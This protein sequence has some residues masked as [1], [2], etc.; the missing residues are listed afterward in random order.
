M[1]HLLVLDTP[2]VMN[3]ISGDGLGTRADEVDF[4]N[5]SYAKGLGQ[6]DGQHLTFS[7]DPSNKQWP[8]D[9]SL[10]VGRPYT[11]DVRVLE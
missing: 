10:P 7:I 4:I 11:S 3:L 9:A 5:V 6:Y 1:F 2:Q 8:S